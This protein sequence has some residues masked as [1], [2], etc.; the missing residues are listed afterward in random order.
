MQRVLKANVYSEEQEN[1][2]KQTRQKNYRQLINNPGFYEFEKYN[3]TGEAC[4][5]VCMHVNEQQFF[6]NPS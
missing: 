4:I 2:L 3:W 5:S 6:C 1:R